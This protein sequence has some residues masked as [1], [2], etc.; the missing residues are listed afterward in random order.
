[1]AERKPSIPLKEIHEIL[2]IEMRDFRYL[3]L[4]VDKDAYSK[5]KNTAELNIVSNFPR[6]DMLLLLA[7]LLAQMKAG[8][9]Y[10]SSKSSEEAFKTTKKDDDEPE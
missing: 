9:A 1:M 10:E 5:D 6:E 8:T 3:I 4:A 2:S 7:D